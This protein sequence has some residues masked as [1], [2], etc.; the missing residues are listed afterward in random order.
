GHGHTANDTTTDTGQKNSKITQG[1]GTPRADGRRREKVKSWKGIGYRGSRIRSRLV[2]SCRALPG[3]GCN[4]PDQQGI[5]I[6]KEIE[7]RRGREKNTVGE[8]LRTPSGKKRDGKPKQGK[9]K[10]RQPGRKGR[11]KRKFN[12]QRQR[13]GMCYAGSYDH[14]I[15]G[16]IRFP[17]PELRTEIHSE[18]G[19]AVRFLWGDRRYFSCGF[20]EEASTSEM[21]THLA[22]RY[23]PGIQYPANHESRRRRH[24]INPQ[25]TNADA[26]QIPRVI[27]PRGISRGE[28]T[29]L[30]QVLPSQATGHGTNNPI[31]ACLP[32]FLSSYFLRVLRSFL[33]YRTVPY[34]IQTKVK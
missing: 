6:R 7:P 27:K 1:T 28:A 23:E 15:P 30:L 12:V 16:T 4:Y 18:F 31:L 32:V 22:M 20:G 9:L 26:V 33:P 34:R 17:A 8:D 5:N 14:E 21:R 19:D 24:E 11:P 2:L 3:R 13:W 10:G 25:S 29:E